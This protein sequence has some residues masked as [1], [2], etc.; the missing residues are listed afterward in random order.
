MSKQS[1]APSSD[2][3]RSPPI[4][5]SRWRRSRSTS[6]RCSQST[7]FSPNVLP[8]AYLP[9]GRIGDGQPREHAAGDRVGVRQICVLERRAVGDRAWGAWSAST[10]RRGRPARARPPRPAG[11]SPSR[12]AA[13]PSSTASS[14]LVF[15]TDS[16]TVA[17]SSGRRLRRSITSASTPAPASVS[18]AASASCTPRMTET[19]VTSAPGRTTR[20]EPIATGSVA[21]LARHRVEPLVLEHDHRVVVAHR[22]RDQPAG[23]VR[24]RRRHDLQAGD[25]LQPRRR[26]LRVDGAEAA[27]AAD[28]AA[29]HERHRRLL[30]GHVPVLGRLVHEAVH[31]RA[32]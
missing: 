16:T 15:S 24:E 14:R 10:R 1:S 32:P 2:R 17:W 4:R 5:S 3:S 12:R 9:S 11:R 23:V 22:G 20:A 28:G 6:T 18:A 19:M 31:R 8:I 26:R 21:D 13:G 27:A 29:D 25:A 7:A 30:V